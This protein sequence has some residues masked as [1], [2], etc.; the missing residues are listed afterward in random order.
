[1]LTGKKTPAELQAMRDGGKIIAQIF[2]E[3]KEFTQP[4][5]NEL[6]IDD[7]VDKK[8]KSYG[9]YPTYKEPDVNFPASIC[10]SV[11]EELIHGIPEDNILEVGDKVSYDLTITYK[12][13]KL[14][15]AFTMIVGEEPKGAKKHLLSLTSSSLYDGIS[16]LRSGVKVGDLSSKIEQTLMA[17]KL[18][19]IREYVGHGI[20]VK[21]H[22]PPDI[23]NYGRK[24]TGPILETGET[25]CIEPMASLG[26]DKTYIKS[27][28]WTVAM[29]DGSLP[30]HFEHTVLITETGAE[31][32]TKL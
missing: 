8:I 6:E 1:M 2:A 26:K 13:M 32:L 12:N 20:G 11:N 27:D 3:L 10:I 15:S 22:M 16:V 29:K 5:L 7:W 24:N 23:P 18:S 31:I 9:A 21:M 17:G 19:I 30:A 4:G 25:I 28:G 14:D